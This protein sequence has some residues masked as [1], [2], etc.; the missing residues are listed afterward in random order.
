MMLKE[1]PEEQQTLFKEILVRKINVRE[2][3]RIA[4]RIAVEKA[5]KK[6]L[7]PDA[8]LQEFENK[9]AETLHTRVHIEPREQGGKI[10]I[11]YFSPEDLDIIMKVFN[12]GESV[13]GIP[14]APALDQHSEASETDEETVALEVPTVTELDDRNPEEKA[15]S[16]SDLDDLYNIKNFSL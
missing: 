16:E 15:Q 3:E 13:S 8:E 14:I 9:L 4:R 7:I 10:T 5:R 6:S 11:D 2:A 1:R 12:E